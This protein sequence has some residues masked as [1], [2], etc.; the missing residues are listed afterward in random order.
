MADREPTREEVLEMRFFEG[1]APPMFEDPPTHAGQRIVYT[2][3]YE[4]EIG[5]GKDDAEAKNT[6]RG[7]ARLWRMVRIGAGLPDD[8][9]DPREVDA[10]GKWHI[11]WAFNLPEAKPPTVGAP[12]DSEDSA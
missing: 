5:K 6:A 9:C 2:M 1:E 8:R 12:S 4:R 11:S 10:N 7:E 3:A